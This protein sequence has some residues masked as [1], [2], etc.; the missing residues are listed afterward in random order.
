[1]AG[2]LS[3]E[4]SSWRVHFRNLQLQPGGWRFVPKSGIIEEASHQ[5]VLFSVCEGDILGFTCSCPKR[6]LAVLIALLLAATVVFG[7]S[8]SSSKKPVHH[9]TVTPAKK[10]SHSPKTSKSNRHYK[11]SKRTARN[12][13]HH[14]QQKIDSQRAREI[15]AALIR[16]HYLDGEPSGVWDAN[17]QKAMERY[18]ADNGWQSKMVPD[19][20]AL[21]KLGLGPDHE[22]LL[23][24]ET[25]MIS[26]QPAT[27]PAA[28]P[29]TSTPATPPP[30]PAN[31]PQNSH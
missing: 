29:A 13:R 25:S 10:T 5:A 15:Q 4:P 6:L 7:E 19:S 16:Q 2:E 9:K 27:P 20:R 17:S 21:I 28:A 26:G 30:T 1:M 18:Q 8:S 23:N 11:Q 31:L 3:Q 14:G 24:P 12:W 22:H